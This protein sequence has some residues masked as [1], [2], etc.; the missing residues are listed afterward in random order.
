[1]K[2]ATY[3]QIAKWIQLRYIPTCPHPHHIAT[4][5]LPNEEAY[6][7]CQIR[8]QLKK[9]YKNACKFQQLQLS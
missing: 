1:M 6:T 4:Y 8:R 3:I 7:D 2:F 9:T 5:K